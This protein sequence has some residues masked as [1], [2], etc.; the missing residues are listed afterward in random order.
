M[1]VIGLRKRRDNVGDISYES[2][3]LRQRCLGIDV[4]LMWSRD[5]RPKCA[6]IWRRT[7]RSNCKNDDC[8]REDKDDDDAVDIQ[9]VQ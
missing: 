1:R 4:A 6:S 9:S 5:M 8:H 7:I 2:F 3:R